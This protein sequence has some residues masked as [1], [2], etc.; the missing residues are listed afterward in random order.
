[1]EAD[2]RL[3]GKVLT[4]Y[5]DGLTVDAGPDRRRAAPVAGL[6]LAGAAYRGV[7]STTSTVNASTAGP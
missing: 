3:G 2:H 1:M 5:P 4:G 6:W 7:A